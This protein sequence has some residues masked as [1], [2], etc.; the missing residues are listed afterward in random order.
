LLN[1]GPGE[2]VEAGEFEVRVV[3]S[4]HAKVL[5]GRVP[6]AGEVHEPPDAPIHAFSFKLGDARAYL[7]TERS[8]GLRIVLLSSADRNLAALEDLGRAAAPIDLL[9]PATLGRDAGYARDLVRTLHPRL[10]MPHH[11][12][13]LFTP[14][15][16]PDA[17]APQD[18]ES[19]A[20]FE[21]ELRSA[22]AEEGLTLEVRR[23]QLFQEFTVRR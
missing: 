13:D 23:L 6:L 8:S 20:A 7:V 16:A 4:E 15:D 3:A 14:I 18:A 5:A 17:A 1:A 21:Q 22:A 12:D 2:I 10:V 19:L 9:L 11:F